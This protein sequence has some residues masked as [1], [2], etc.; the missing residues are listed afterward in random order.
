[1][2]S[3]I[4][5]LRVAAVQMESKNGAVEENLERA[6][7]FAEEAA[8][9]G[10]KLIVFPEFMPTGYIFTDEI[11]SAGETRTGP[12]MRWLV[13][14]SRRLGAWI[15]TSFLE[16][17]RDDF[18]NTFVITGPEGEEAGAVRKQ[19]P[20]AVEACF[21]K[22]DPGNHVIE[23]EFGR[24][25]IGI[26]YENQLSYIQ[27]LLY[28]Q[29]V[30]ILLMPHSAPAPTPTPLLLKK[31]LG[32]FAGILGRLPAHYVK[33]LGVP[34]VFVNKSGPFSSPV[35]GLPFY[36]QDSFFPGESKILDSDGTLVAGLGAEEGVVVGEVR[37]DPSR[38]AQSPPRRYCRWSM[39]IPLEMNAFAVAEAAGRVSYRLSRTRKRMAREISSGRL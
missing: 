14:T 19:S 6:G 26:C 15:G 37:L 17:E 25:G 27:E 33:S 5:D 7:G 34:V 29:S 3:G 20:A 30:D 2:V 13:D 1:M 38:K 31:R 8:G 16:A 24:I 35:P 10:A 18:Y 39:K 32:E 21:F 9:Q 36:D 11:W 4:K 23:T 22:G 28:S 12:T